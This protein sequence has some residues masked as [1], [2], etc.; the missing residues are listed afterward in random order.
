MKRLAAN[1]TDN[2]FNSCHL[3]TIIKFTVC[4]LAI[5]L[6]VS[7]I[8]G[9]SQYKGPYTFWRQDKSNIEKIEICSY[10]WKT[11]TRT[12]LAELSDAEA[13]EIM[14]E[15]SEIE[16][17][18]WFVPPPSDFGPHIICITYL[19]GEIEVIG[20]ICTGYISPDGSEKLTYYGIAEESG[21]FYDL[22]GKYVDLSLLDDTSDVYTEYAETY[23]K[24]S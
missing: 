22:I 15:L 7:A 11:K 19:D 14:S 20:S 17:V 24:E 3:L 9:C 13:E 1:I 5:V 23:E 12:S 2:R 4:L 10:D 8:A 16:F 6:S 21:S 18:E